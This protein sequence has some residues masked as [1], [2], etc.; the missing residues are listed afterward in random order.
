[1]KAIRIGNDIRIEWPVNF[2]A[3]LVTGKG[4]D[5]QVHVMPSKRIDDL[6]NADRCHVERKTYRVLTDEGVAYRELMP[7][8]PPPRPVA[9]V[10]LNY[11]IDNG[12]LTAI[13][14][15]NMQF[16]IGD[17]DIVMT[18]RRDKVGQAIADV[19]RFCRLVEHSAQADLPGNTDVEAVIAVQPITLE[20]SGLSAY[21]IACL[22]GY[23]GT[24]EEWIAQYDVTKF[25]TYASD[26][27]KAAQAI[28]NVR[29]FLS[30]S[31]Q[32][33]SYSQKNI[34]L[35]YDVK[36]TDASGAWKSDSEQV[37]INAATAATAGV[38]SNTDKQQLEA[39]TN[40]GQFVVTGLQF[41]AAAGEIT[42]DIKAGYGEDYEYEKAT[43][44]VGEASSSKSGLMSAAMCDKLTGIDSVPT[45]E[46]DAI[47]V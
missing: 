31:Q 22:Y 21:D 29:Q 25:V 32:A 36:K 5:L 28:A 27:G 35:G 41:D 37:Q 14:P 47:C 33:V 1:M 13:W 17:Y 12:V 4:L 7:M 45:S 8:V 16:A 40:G 30:S 2:D 39:L 23:E 44:L 3:E 26:A 6:R 19:Y 10:R 43:P 15:G 24:E 20:L 38:M 42:Y 18:Y 46:I 34:A 11:S 9:P